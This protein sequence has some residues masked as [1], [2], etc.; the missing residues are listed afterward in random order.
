LCAE[1]DIVLFDYTKFGYDYNAL[2]N[3][4]KVAVNTGIKEIPN[5]IACY[6][7]SAADQASQPQRM[8]GETFGLLRLKARM[9]MARAPPKAA[10]KQPML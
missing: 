4:Q 5:A 9:I 10:T 1:T 3:G 8:S 7:I 2:K 6:V